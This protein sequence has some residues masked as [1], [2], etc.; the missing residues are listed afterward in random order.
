MR[1]EIPSRTFT[2]RP[3]SAAPI[4][5]AALTALVLAAAPLPLRAQSG[6]LLVITV[7]FAERV[8]PAGGSYYIAFTVDET[9]LAGP[10]SDSS[11]WTHYV[12]LRGGRFYLGRV[13]ATPFRPFGF[14]T[15]RPPEPF[16]YGQILP[17][18]RGVRVRLPLS[19]LATGAVP[20]TVIKMNVV[21]VDEL[22]RPLD[23]LGPGAADRF[24]F[25]TLNLI[26]Q[27]YVTLVDPA[28]DAADPSFDIT[29]GDVQLTTP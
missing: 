7:Q 27:T 10:Q 19:A 13:P 16:S 8:R 11:N 12:L 9:L 6:P 18:G 25:V 14:E 20:P 26:R 5:T 21:T 24:G 28:R 4:L 23:A 22:L 1:R 15:I 29:G 3:R 17:D 2:P